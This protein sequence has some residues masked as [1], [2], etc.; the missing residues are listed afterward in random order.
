MNGVEKSSIYSMSSIKKLMLVGI[1]LLTITGCSRAQETTNNEAPEL[2]APIVPLVYKLGEEIKYS[3]VNFT[4]ESSS[5]WNKSEPGF[6]RRFMVKACVMGDTAYTF[7]AIN[8]NAISVEG[9]QFTTSTFW[10]PAPEWLKPKFP[11]TS[12]PVQPGNCLRGLIAFETSEEI[13]QVVYANIMDPTA[14]TFS[15]QAK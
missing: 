2:D 12:I 15:V 4:V 5:D 9:S 3:D 8:W 13:S 6:L 11:V 10:D 14:P 7:S 1:V